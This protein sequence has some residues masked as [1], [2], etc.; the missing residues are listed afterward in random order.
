VNCHNFTDLAQLHAV[1]RSGGTAKYQRCGDVDPSDPTACHSVLDARPADFNAAASCGEGT[2]GCHADKNPTNHGYDSAKHAAVLGS[3]EVAMGL[4][5]TDINHAGWGWT[6]N[7]ECS[8]C[9]YSDLG[10]QHGGQCPTCHSGANP[11]G[12]LGT[13]DKSCQQGDCHPAI[14]T[15]IAPDHNGVYTGEAASCDLCHT[16]TWPGEVDC[17][18]CHDAPVPTPDTVAPTTVSDA[19]SSYVG[20]TTIHLTATDNVGGRGVDSTYFILDGGS[21]T[22]GTTI[23]VTA[24]TSGSQ[25]HTLQFYSVDKAGNVETTTPVPALS[26]SVVP[27]PDTTPP[28]GTMSVDNGA[29][30]A[31]STTATVNS[32]VSDAESG[33]DQMRID[34]GTGVFGM[35]TAYS[36]DATVTLSPVDGV[37]T[38]RAEYRDNASNVATLTDTILLDTTPPSTT[39]N[40]GASYVGAVS[41]TLTATD[42]PMGSGV[43]STRYRVD[44]GG[45]Q[46]GTAISVAAPASG[47][48][49]HTIYFWSVDIATK[50]EA[51]NSTTFS[52]AQTA[53]AMPTGRAQGRACHRPTA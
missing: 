26:F 50:T 15:G 53:Y 9:H 36:A 18:R 11:V 4:G 12:S 8:L 13:W 35:W 7:V 2:G 42:G 25:A 21:A 41:I 10:T 17:N 44:S 5:A 20:D 23:N 39:S 16:P 31:I 6:T 40:V 27:A 19:T 30:Y 28:S 47:S 51:E 22:L 52:V 46:I 43:A 48:V 34:P 33:M 32:A 1:G 45:E 14:H 49:S 24:P 29:A 37:K 38:V 3:G